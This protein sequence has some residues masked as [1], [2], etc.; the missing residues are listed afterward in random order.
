MLPQDFLKDIHDIGVWVAILVLTFLGGVVRT[1]F[2]NK[3]QI[4]LLKKELDARFK[5]REKH[6]E[7]MKNVL[8]RLENTVDH[9]REQIL[10]LWKNNR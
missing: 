2:T 3:A 1:I 4:E 5:S 7:D 9:T 10:E 8:E 6:D